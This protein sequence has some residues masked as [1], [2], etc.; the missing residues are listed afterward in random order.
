MTVKRGTTDCSPYRPGSYAPCTADEPGPFA[1]YRSGLLLHSSQYC[2]E[3]DLTDFDMLESGI[4]SLL[5]NVRPCSLCYSWVDLNTTSCHRASSTASL[6]RPGL[7]SSPGTT[8]LWAC[9]LRTTPSARA[10]CSFWSRAPSVSSL[11][12]MV[13]PG[14]SL[15]QDLLEYFSSL[16]IRCI[17]QQRCHY[18]VVGLLPEDHTFSKGR[19]FLLEPK[20]KCV[21]FDVDGTPPQPA[22][23]EGTSCTWASP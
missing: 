16:V 4:F 6:Y 21:I 3:S 10:C 17:A 14:T 20:P 11:T 8:P 7:P 2:G 5:G 9:C 18:S 23:H 12:L 19:P 15:I 13:R 22:L 1:E